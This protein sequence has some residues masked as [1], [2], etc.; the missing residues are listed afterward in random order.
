[1]KQIHAY[2]SMSTMDAGSQT[3]CGG[4]DAPIIII[5]IIIIHAL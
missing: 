4:M 3:E 1:M 5:I 2:Q